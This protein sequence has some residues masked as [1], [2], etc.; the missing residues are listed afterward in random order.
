MPSAKEDEEAIK[1]IRRQ[2]AE[3]ERENKD[4]GEKLFELREKLAKL[5][6]KET[7]SSDEKAKKLA[8]EEEIQSLGRIQADLDG[9]I[10]RLNEQLAA[11]THVR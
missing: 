4:H 5:T 9:A 1:S 10:R 7:P 2:I 3:Q 11:T 8:I 6:V